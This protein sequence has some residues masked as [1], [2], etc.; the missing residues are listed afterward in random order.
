MLQVAGVLVVQDNHY[1]LQHRNDIPTIAYPGTY[2]IWGGT[3]EPGEEPLQG[4][5]RELLEETGIH[6]NAVDLI[7]L[8]EFEVISVGPETR[9]QTIRAYAYALELASDQELHCYEGQGIISLKIGL[10][11][12]EKLNEYAVKAIEAYESHE[13]AR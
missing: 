13:S 11:L 2:T 10:P 3:V 4:A 7:K 1:L 6:A 9:G 12:P 8:C 5:L